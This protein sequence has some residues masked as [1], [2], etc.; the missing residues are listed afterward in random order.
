MG[1]LDE[2]R[3]AQHDRVVRFRGRRVEELRLD[4]GRGLE[5]HPVPKEPV[6][7]AVAHPERRDL[8]QGER[9]EG[10][11]AQLAQSPRRLE[12]DPA[13]APTQKSRIFSAKS[14]AWVRWPNAVECPSSA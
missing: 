9:Q 6:G 10:D 3:V 12:P 1:V 13:H 14:C 5:D 7:E 4:H 2:R 11:G 8:E